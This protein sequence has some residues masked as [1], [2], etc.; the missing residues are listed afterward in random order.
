MVADERDCVILPDN[1]SFAVGAYC[2]C[3]AGTAYQVTKRLKISGL[4][5]VVIFGC[6]PVGLATT[7]FAT[8]Q[9]GRVIAVDVNEKRL[10]LAKEIGA[11]F[12]I[13]PKKNNVV[14]EVMQITEGEG[15][16]VTI[17]CSAN[18]EARIAALD[19]AKIWGRTAYVGEGNKT[20]IDPSP[21]I[22]H[23]ELTLIGSWVFSLTSMMELLELLS[24]HS[25]PLEDLITNR[26]VI[27]DAK[28]AF[29]AFSNG[30]TSGKAVFEWT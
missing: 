30:Q 8:F 28:R 3:G 19:C 2:S 20:T 13:N 24:R 25:L 10:D 12:I 17:D 6:G 22:L 29:E 5:N 15:A 27:E 11:K 4:D 7:L 18:P 21:Q 26:F 9:G 14:E 1:L 23:K 16:E